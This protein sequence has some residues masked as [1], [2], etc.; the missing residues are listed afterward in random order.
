MGRICAHDG[1]VL[2]RLLTQP[3][4]LPILLPFLPLRLLDLQV[5]LLP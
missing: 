3:H 2:K 1:P 5:S 4:L